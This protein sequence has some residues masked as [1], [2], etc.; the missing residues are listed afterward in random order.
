MPFFVFV[1]EE[2]FRGVVCFLL[3]IFQIMPQTVFNLSLL[4]KFCPEFLLVSLMVLCAFGLK[5]LKEIKLEVMR[6][7]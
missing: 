4:A 7:G 1:M 3:A 6:S 5:N 2:Y